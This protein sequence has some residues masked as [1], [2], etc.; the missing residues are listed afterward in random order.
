MS[1]HD[2]PTVN[3]KS[4]HFESQGA[5]V[6]INATDFDPAKGHVLYEP[7]AIK[8]PADDTLSAPL[9]GDG[10][11]EELP[12]VD[13]APHAVRRGRPVKVTKGEPL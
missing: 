13:S 7:D 10:T 3:I 5:F 6:V 1:S 2:I 12:P 9:V 4:T 8:V 11:G